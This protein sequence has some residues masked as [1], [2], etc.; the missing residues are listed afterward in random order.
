MV[1]VGL[2][3]DTHGLLRP[4]A[5]AALT[6]CDLIV[7]AGDVGG[8]AV[9][10]ALRAIAPVYAVAGNVDDPTDPDLRPHVDLDVAGCHIHVVHGHQEGS[11]SAERLTERIAADVIIFGHTHRALVRRVAGTLV[12]NP[13]SAG[14]SRFG[15]PV[16]VGV[17]VVSEG[18]A[19]AEIVDLNVLAVP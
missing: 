13:G 8:P 10:P 9:L 12:V 4:A 16:T 19:R 2:I 18:Q 3:S 5:I 1:R 7:H 14:P 6:G 17:L 15:L 11:P